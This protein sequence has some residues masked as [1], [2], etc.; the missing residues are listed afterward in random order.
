[1]N[2]SEYLPSSFGSK[3]LIGSCESIEE[4]ESINYKEF[5]DKFPENDLLW[6]ISNG[7]DPAS[8][9][10]KTNNNNTNSKMFSSSSAYLIKFWVD[11]NYTIEEGISSMYAVTNL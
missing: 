1:M 5:A 7:F 6:S 8:T 10:E 4:F 9:I 2:T 3:Q 11:L